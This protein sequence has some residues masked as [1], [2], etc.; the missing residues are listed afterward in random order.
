MDDT[1]FIV[2][3]SFTYLGIPYPHNITSFHFILF[4][5]FLP[6]TTAID[7][8]D[9]DDGSDNESDDDN[10]DSIDRHN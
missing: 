3:T 2:F 9:N 8:N 5:S 1:S 7:I 4:Y 10:D 6:P